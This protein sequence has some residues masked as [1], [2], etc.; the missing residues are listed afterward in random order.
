MPERNG[1]TRRQVF[2]PGLAALGVALALATG[3]T[4]TVGAAEPA[5][6][7]VRLVVDFGD[8][9]ELHFTKLPWRNEMTVLDALAAAAKH[10]RGVEFKQR[11]SGGSALITQIGDLK[12]GGG[13]AQTKNW[14]FYVNGKHAKTSAGAQPLEPGDVAL[15]RFQVYDYNP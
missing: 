2:G 15:W 14:M 8:G 12:N 1:Q 4:R 10:R 3:T 7:T 6:Q 9:V 13:G 5:S 11:G